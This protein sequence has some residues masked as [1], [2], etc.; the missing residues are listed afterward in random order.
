MLRVLVVDDH[1]VVR[2]GV[3]NLLA[4]AEDMRI[5]GVAQSAREAILR[6]RELKPD[7][8]LLDLRLPDMLGNDALPHL[9]AAAPK[10]KVVIFTA[11]DEHAALSAA[12]DAGAHGALLKDVTDLVEQLRKIAAGVKVIDPRLR[13][14]GRA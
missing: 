10:A 13:S 5:V 2:G 7:V 9:R 11:H 12:L 8:V 1:P 3:E 14:A 4:A 6:A